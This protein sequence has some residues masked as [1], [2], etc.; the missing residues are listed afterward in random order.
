MRVQ[1]G[2][3]E[4]FR[5]FD[6]PGYQQVLRFTAGGRSSEEP[7]AA[8]IV[9]SLTIDQLEPLKA[10]NLFARALLLADKPT[11]VG[12][13]QPKP[14][15][16]FGRPGRISCATRP[17]MEWPATAKRSGAWKYEP[18]HFR[19]RPDIRI[20]CDRD[21][22]NFLKFGSSV[23]V[24]TVTQHPREQYEPGFSYVAA[25]QSQVPGAHGARR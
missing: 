8:Q 14:C 21:L 16:A 11:V 2:S 4:P 18:R 10:T 7:I 13:K 9:K 15:H 23:I 20:L 5:H 17:P 3:P 6:Q 12:A 24:G 1:S 25:Y 22:R 19:D